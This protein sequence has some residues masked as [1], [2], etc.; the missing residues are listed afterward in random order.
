MTCLSM[1]L[2]SWIA[3][4]APFSDEWPRFCHV[5]SRDMSHIIKEELP[6]FQEDLPIYAENQSRRNNL[7]LIGVPESRENLG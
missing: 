6:V 2:P 7:K 4:T 3:V 1:H 5:P